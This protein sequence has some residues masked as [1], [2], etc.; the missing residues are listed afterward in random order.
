MNLTK[1]FTL[2]ELTKTNTGLSNVPHTEALQNLTKLANLLQII[3]DAYG[4]PI[5]VTSGFRNMAVN[6]KVGGS[7]TSD[8]LYGAAAD[9]KCN[10]NAKL[11]EL[12]N[13]LLV[14]NKISC[15]QLIW[16]Y[17]TKECP[18]WIHISINNKH[19]KYK[20]NQILYIGVK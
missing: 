15:R 7:N 5:I 9:I 6:I 17:G 2:E 8:H 13:H 19:N 20:K 1:N 11:W 4:Q 16:E 18:S 10:D 14:T 3:R 12:I